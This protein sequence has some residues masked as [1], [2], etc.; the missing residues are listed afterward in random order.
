MIL[1]VECETIQC[2]IKECMW[3]HL[4]L[5]GNILGIGCKDIGNRYK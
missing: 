2:L 1:V 5:A 4:A 3:K